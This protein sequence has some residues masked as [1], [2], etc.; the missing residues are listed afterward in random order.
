MKGIIAKKLSR[1]AYN[2]FCRDQ[3]HK[4][5]YDSSAWRKIR[6]MKLA[7]NPVCEACAAAGRM[8]KAEMVHHLIPVKKGSRR[9]DMDFLVSLCNPCHNAIESEIEK[10]GDG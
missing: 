7:R 10:E 6:A 3:E 1:D 5:F 8:V 2:R 9:L 4:K